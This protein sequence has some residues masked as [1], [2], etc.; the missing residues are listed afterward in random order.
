MFY[1]TKVR[2]RE[3]SSKEIEVGKRLFRIEILWERGRTVNVFNIIGPIMIG[4]SSSH[5][6]GAVRLGRVVNKLAEGGT[7]K[8]VDIELSGSFARTYRGHGTDR[9]LLAGIMGYHSY[10]EEIRNALQIAKDRGIDYRFIEEDIPGAHP[11][12]ARIHYVLENGQKGVMEGASIGGGN[13]RVD[14]VNGM[15]VDFTGENNTVLVL[16]KDKPGAIAEVTQI[17]YEKYKDLNI[18]NFRLSRPEKGGT[19]LMTIE[20][21]QLPPKELLEDI[22]ALPVVEN[23][24]LIRA[25]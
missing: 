17:M 19:A 14:S 12:T 1:G 10:N 21:D 25:I 3:F 24:I 5:T 9:A 18:G 22:N 15:R 2:R 11:N 4:P 20:I 23:A 13:I 6:A 7:F 16:H 8:T